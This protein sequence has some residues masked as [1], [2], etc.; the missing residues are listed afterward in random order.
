MIILAADANALSRELIRELLEGSGQVDEQFG[1]QQIFWYPITLTDLCAQRPATF[2]I[3]HS[4]C[5]RQ[6]MVYST[7]ETESSRALPTDCGRDQ[8]QTGGYAEGASRLESIYEI[9]SSGKPKPP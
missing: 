5:K 7:L 4:G 6:F 3:N 8:R 2:G 9:G 1:F